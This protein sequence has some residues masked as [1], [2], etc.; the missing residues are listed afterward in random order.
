MILDVDV[1][2]NHLFSSCIFPLLVD[3]R[4]EYDSAANMDY[5]QGGNNEITAKLNPSERSVSTD[6]G[7]TAESVGTMADGRG[8][9][10][11]RA[12]SLIEARAQR[13][14][15]KAAK[16][17]NQHNLTKW[18]NRDILFG[19]FSAPKLSLEIM[20]G[21][22][23]T[24]QK[25]FDLC[26]VG[27][28]ASLSKRSFDTRLF[29]AVEGVSASTDLSVPGD[30]LFVNGG[31]KPDDPRAL[32]A[33]YSHLVSSTFV[34]EDFLCVGIEMRNRIDKTTGASKDSLRCKA[35]IGVTELCVPNSQTLGQWLDF[36]KQT[37]TCF[38]RGEEGKAIKD[39]GPSSI[40]ASET[41]PL[42]NKLHQK[43]VGKAAGP[44]N[45]G[46]RSIDIVVQ[47]DG[48]TVRL[49]DPEHQINLREDLEYA[50]FAD[51]A[52]LVNPPTANWA[53][54]KSSLRLI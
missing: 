54:S 49:A 23:S 46:S 35:A 47:A 50:Q 36:A 16:Q 13:A 15:L 8:E 52:L 44:D 29:A 45:Q 4:T 3:A 2:F 5:R 37:K 21:D 1:G 10:L 26:V 22:E 40:S 17:E 34:Q 31:V 12:K 9:L 11:V 28:N 33:Q 51:D 30:L 32:A 43:I 7:P 41:S 18:L 19:A 24:H 14:S 25:I 39:P 48:M 6:G 27:I 38:E 42:I 20:L 53:Y